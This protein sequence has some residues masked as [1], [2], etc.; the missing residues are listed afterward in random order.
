MFL[1][2]IVPVYNAEAYLEECLCSLLEQDIPSGEYEVICVNDGSTDGSREILSS[3][4]AQF[5]NLVLI[6]QANSGVSAARNAGLKAARGAFVWFV[7]ADDFLRPN[8]LSVLFGMSR[9]T[10]CDRI[11]VGGYQFKDALSPQETELSREGNLPINTP[12]PDAV[13]WRSLFRRAFLSEHVLSFRYPQLTHGEDG[14]FMYEV[15]CCSPVTVTV[16]AVFYFYRVHGGSAETAVSMEN[17]LK[18]LRSHIA[19]TKIMQ[20]FYSAGRKDPAT[21]N[22]LMSSLWLS[23]Y[24]T[25]RL[26]RKEARRVLRELREAGLFPFRRL[27]ECTMTRSYLTERGGIAGRILDGIYL[28]LHTRWG[29]ALCRTVQQLLSL[30]RRR[31]G[32]GT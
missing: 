6:D 21:A 1:S 18:K 11:L 26:P 31:A 30:A 12:G 17:Q 25:S 4:A 7:D 20:G 22:R 14:L 28:H 15:S 16:N 24:V 2:F 8:I 3:F 27:P 32:A 9:E 23:L 10:P 29:F 19:I 13:V 5:P